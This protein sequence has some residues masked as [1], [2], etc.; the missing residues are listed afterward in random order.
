MAT[1]SRL[2]LLLCSSGLSWARS[3]PNSSGGNYPS[4]MPEKPEFQVEFA[5]SKNIY[6]D[7]NPLHPD[8]EIAK[9]LKRDRPASP[10]RCFFV[11]ASCQYKA[12]QGDWDKLDCVNDNKVV[13]C[14]QFECTKKQ[15]AFQKA[16]EAYQKIIEGETKATLDQ[17][18]KLE[19]QR[20][21]ILHQLK[22]ARERVVKRLPTNDPKDFFTVASL[23]QQTKD[24]LMTL[25]QVAQAVI[26]SKVHLE[27]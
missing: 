6:E 10:Q 13:D 11:V 21:K 9:A 24:E 14:C 26:H 20:Q 17:L 25:A 12:K 2:I 1:Y 7:G 5:T 23:P 3:K 18:Q 22:N 4:S 16:K 8:P 15:V 27:P 19:N